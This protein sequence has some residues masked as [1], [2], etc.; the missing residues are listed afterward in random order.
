MNDQN[1]EKN[2][3]WWWWNETTVETR[4]NEMYDKNLKYYYETLLR[5][6]VTRLKSAKIIFYYSSFE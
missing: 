3:Q 1:N 4:R 5:F 2:Q 6:S